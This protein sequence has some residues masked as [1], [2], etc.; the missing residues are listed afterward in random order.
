M[1]KTSKEYGEALFALA[2][3]QNMTS[4]IS[5]ALKSVSDVFDKNP[6]Y[7]DFLACYG[8]PVAERTQALESAFSDALPEY[9]LSFLQL[10]CE[11]GAIKDFFDCVR[12][13]EAL[14]AEHLKKSTAVVTSARPLDDMQKQALIKKLEA[15]CNH[16]VQLE[17]RTDESVL[18]GLI[19]EVDGKVIDGSL[20]RRLHDVKEVIDK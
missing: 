14:F 2:L 1:T 4:Q 11:R 3:E 10:L 9:A 7:I 13:Y 5:D 16:S 20:K 15:M 19:I 6:E 12:V 18:G 17:C 8:I